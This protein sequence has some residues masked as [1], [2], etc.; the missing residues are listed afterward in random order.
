MILIEESYGLSD[1]KLKA[2]T[3]KVLV[4]AMSTAKYS[5]LLTKTGLFTANYFLT[6]LM[7]NIKESDYS[8]NVYINIIKKFNSL[9]KLK[10][11]IEIKLCTQ[12]LQLIVS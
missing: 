11:S 9:I 10:S 1:R 4:Y 2:L 5:Y 6:T 3:L 7:N 8:K 12:E